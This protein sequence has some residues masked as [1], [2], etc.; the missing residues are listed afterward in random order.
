MT[1]RARALL[2]HRVDILPPSLVLAQAA[3]DRPVRM[4]VPNPA[5]G[6]LDI[7][8]RTLADKVKDTLGPVIVENRAGAGGNIATEAAVRA[9]PDGYTILLGTI[10]GGI[11][12][13]G[14]PAKF[15]LLMIVFSLMCWG[16]SLLIP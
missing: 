16:A 9:A 15:A 13:S 4:V 8:A 7:V 12:H 10:V 6:P 3:A 5:G 2:L 14:D 11:A 1:A